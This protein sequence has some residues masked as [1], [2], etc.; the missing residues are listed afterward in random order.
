MTDDTASCAFTRADWRYRRA[1]CSR[2]RPGG[3]A[4]AVL[5]PRRPWEGPGR[6]LALFL[7]S[8]AFWLP[9]AVL[10]LVWAARP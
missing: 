3:E 8:A 5:P 9:A 6:A 2:S 4:F 7:G 1:Q 10:A